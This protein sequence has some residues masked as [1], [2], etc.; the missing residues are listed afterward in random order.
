MD[1]KLIP[2]YPKNI[3]R[4]RTSTALL[5]TK[6]IYIT[7]E[8]KLLKSFHEQQNTHSVHTQLIIRS[9]HKSSGRQSTSLKPY[10]CL[11]ACCRWFRCSNRSCSCSCLP[12][13]TNSPVPPSQTLGVLFFPLSPPSRKGATHNQRVSSSSA[14]LQG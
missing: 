10:R 2:P 5:I 8:H 4:Y 14:R 7:I 13:T 11:V 6:K 9:R 3:N 1:T 12:T